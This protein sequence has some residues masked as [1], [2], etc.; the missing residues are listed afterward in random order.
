VLLLLVFV[1]KLETKKIVCLREEKKIPIS[2]QENKKSFS[3]YFLCF[4]C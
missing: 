1:E 4:Y 3:Q 2:N